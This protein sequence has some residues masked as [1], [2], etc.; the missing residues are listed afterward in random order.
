[1]F[2]MQIGESASTFKMQNVG[3]FPTF[4]MQYV[5]FSKLDI[6]VLCLLRNALISLVFRDLL[7]RKTPSN[8]YIVPKSLQLGSRILVMILLLAR[9]YIIQEKKPTSWH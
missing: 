5:V 6:L 7:K 9:N 3:T 4:E 1:M 2:E 8:Y